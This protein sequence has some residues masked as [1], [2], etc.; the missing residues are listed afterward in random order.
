EMAYHNERNFDLVKEM[1]FDVNPVSETGTKACMIPYHELKRVI[2]N[3]LD[4]ENKDEEQIYLG[5][6]AL[7]WL[8][9]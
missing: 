6:E 3:E 2:Y 5:V 7:G 4:P 8:W 9:L 1:F